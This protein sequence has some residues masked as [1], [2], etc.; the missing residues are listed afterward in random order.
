MAKRARRRAQD[1]DSEDEDPESDASF[2]PAVKRARSGPHKK[3]APKTPESRLAA[4]VAHPASAHVVADPAPLRDALLKWYAGVH[5]ARRMPWRK[6]YDPSWGPAQRAQRAYE[7]S[8]ACLL[9]I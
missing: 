8:P 6:P 5:D 3:P 1:D 7:A 2:A 4:V 9:A